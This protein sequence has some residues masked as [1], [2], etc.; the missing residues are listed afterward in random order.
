MTTELSMNRRSWLR[1][2][3]A[4]A[5]ALP[6]L[7]TPVWA[8]GAATGGNHSLILIEL[9]GGNDG[10]NTLIPF[11]DDNYHRARPTLALSG[12]EVLGLNSDSGLHPSL[13]GL[14]RT[15]ERGDLRLIEGVGY[16]DPNRSHFRSIEIWNAG[17]GADARPPRAGSR[18]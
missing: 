3:G 18:A 7:S 5:A 14:A 4:S 13:G 8:A 15:W 1:L 11:R 12:S 16:P 17:M 2:L 6:V 9:E 10:L